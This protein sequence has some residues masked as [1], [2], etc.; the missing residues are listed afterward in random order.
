MNEVY[1][2]V[3]LQLDTIP[4][5]SLTSQ[6]LSLIALRSILLSEQKL[7]IYPAYLDTINFIRSKIMV[8][9]DTLDVAAVDAIVNF[10]RVDLPIRTYRGRSL[11][12]IV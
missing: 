3:L 1:P 2:F 5:S 4:M 10:L 12:E 6:V 8:T 11:F 7:D 9:I